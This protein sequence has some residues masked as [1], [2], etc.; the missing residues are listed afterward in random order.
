ME[1]CCQ[2]V[3]SDHWIWPRLEQG[4]ACL[5]VQFRFHSESAEPPG[6]R[7][8]VDTQEGTHLGTF[9]KQLNRPGVGGTSKNGVP[10][11]DNS[12]PARQEGGKKDKKEKVFGLLNGQTNIAAH[13]SFTILKQ[14]IT[15]SKGEFYLVT[16]LNSKYLGL[17]DDVLI[18]C[19]PP[20]CSCNGKQL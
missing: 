17:Q 14:Y 7:G 20:K 10:T 5:L 9:Y 3:E 6:T 12:M 15:G 19:L 18:F 2:P 16:A 13:R 11:W 1:I 8:C 4:S